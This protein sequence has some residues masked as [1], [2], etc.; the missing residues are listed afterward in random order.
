MHKYRVG[1]QEWVPQDILHFTCLNGLTLLPVLLEA[2]TFSHLGQ[3]GLELRQIW[4]ICFALDP[5]GS[6]KTSWVHQ[7]FCSK[8]IWPLGHEARASK[9][10]EQAVGW[11]EDAGL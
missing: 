6:R 11:E 7:Y 1:T 3:A 4:T 9:D 8:Q 5:D 10:A 2:F